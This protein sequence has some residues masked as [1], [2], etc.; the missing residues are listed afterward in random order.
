MAEILD[1]RDKGE[2]W[3]T[4]F[5]EEAILAQRTEHRRRRSGMAAA[6]QAQRGAKDRGAIRT[7]PHGR[8]VS[9]RPQP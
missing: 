7:R 2:R 6:R 1:L 5:T 4:S 9:N 3:L 8:A